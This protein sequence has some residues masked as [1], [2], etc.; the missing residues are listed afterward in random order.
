MGAKPQPCYNRIRAIN[1]RVIMRLQCIY[2]AFFLSVNC[3]FEGI[4]FLH[5]YKGVQ[6][7]VTGKSSN[8]SDDPSTYEEMSE[9]QAEKRFFE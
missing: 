3:Y 2:I 7:F 5:D 4:I 9:A 8:S 1:D 6:D